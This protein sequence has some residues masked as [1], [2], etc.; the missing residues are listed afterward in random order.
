MH[1]LD[2][3]TATCKI[4]A[5]KSAEDILNQRLVVL[6]DAVRACWQMRGS[7]SFEL[8]AFF[9]GSLRTEVAGAC[10]TCMTCCRTA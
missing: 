7:W 5:A 1:L 6:K 9:K 8:E 4:V 2:R 3:V 10:R